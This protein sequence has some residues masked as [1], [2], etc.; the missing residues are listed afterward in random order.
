M[1]RKQAESCN[2]VNVQKLSA[3]VTSI[4]PVT[5]APDSTDRDI[6]VSLMFGKVLI[7]TDDIYLAQN[8]TL[9]SLLNVM[10]QYTIIVIFHLLI[11]FIAYQLMSN[12]LPFMHGQLA[13]VFMLLM[14]S[15]LKYF[16]FPCGSAAFG[17]I[18]YY[19]H[20]CCILWLLYRQKPTKK[21]CITS[22]TIQELQQ[23]HFRLRTECQSH[24]KHSD[25]RTGTY[26]KSV[27]VRLGQSLKE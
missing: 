2:V 23:E 7:E 22:E 26:E 15:V 18:C 24:N 11:R 5:N 14:S 4:V 20:K 1:F 21:L 19:P 8:K 3:N 27:A 13:V 10:S 17:T 12:A 16:M 9:Q 25:S 6:K